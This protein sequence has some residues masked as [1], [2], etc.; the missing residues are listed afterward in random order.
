MPL[1]VIRDL[2]ALR[3]AQYGVREIAIIVIAA[4][5]RHEVRLILEE[6]PVYPSPAQN[7]YDN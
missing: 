5:K 1:Q 2:A 3:L 6:A 4:D 7:D